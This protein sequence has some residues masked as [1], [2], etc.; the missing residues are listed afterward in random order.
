MR[1][2]TPPVSPASSRPARW[3]TFS[4]PITVGVAA[5]TALTG[6]AALSP[7][8]HAVTLDVDAH[9]RTWTGAARTVAGALRAAHVPYSANDQITPAADQPVPANGTIRVR[10]AHL[11]TFVLDGA[12]DTRTSTAATVGELVS[13]LTGPSGPPAADTP[14]STVLADAS[15]PVHLTSA[16]VV[17]VAIDGTPTPVGTHAGDVAGVLADAHVN[18]GPDDA[19]SVPLT[20]A[21]HDGTVVQV[22]RATTTTA[23]DTVPIPAPSTNVPNPA[24]PAGST[25]VVAPGSDGVRVR[26]WKVVSRSGAELSRTLVGEQ[27]T[28]PVAQVVAVGTATP[29]PSPAATSDTRAVGQQLAAARGWSGS[30]WTCLNQLWTK[31]SSWR[32]TADNPSSDAYGIP[33]ALP[34]SKMA[35]AGADWRTNPATQITWGLGY[36]AA[37]YGSPCGAWAHEQS[38]GWY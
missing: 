14:A 31:E 7:A 33:Q 22:S 16:K 28:D 9:T 1:V 19:V 27:V 18:L 20:S 24:L 34:G 10:H 21:V 35:S 3:A 30:Q 11:V 36:I 15:V 12:S 8:A 17:T 25:Q 2:L 4:A 5:I 23:T 13:D 6:L 26:T 29:P 32:T 38:T 37:S